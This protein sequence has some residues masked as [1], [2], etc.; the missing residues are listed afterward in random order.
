MDV[1]WWPPKRVH[2]R[3]HLPRGVQ[4]AGFQGVV[5]CLIVLFTPSLLPLA[6]IE[7]TL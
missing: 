5:K 6:S 2:R 4:H 1:T 3:P 7:S